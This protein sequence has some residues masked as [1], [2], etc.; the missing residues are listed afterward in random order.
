MTDMTAAGEPFRIG[1]CLS[2]SLSAFFSNFV[3]LNILGVIILIPGAV[4]VYLL[5]GGILT[6]LTSWVETNT[7]L[8]SDMVAP[9]I[10]T[11]L[12]IL[13]IMIVWQYLVTGAV[14]FS[15]V[16]NLSGS[17]PSPFA[18]LAQMLRRLV[19]V[20]L[21]AII[22]TI[23]VWLGL[24]LFIVPGI[25]VALML[26]V[27]IPVVMAEGTGIRASLSRSRVLTKGSRWKLLGLFLV[28]AIGVTIVSELISF[29][30]ELAV[31]L[32]ETGAIIQIVVGIA[33]QVITTVFMAVVLAVTYHDLRVSKEGASTTQI[34]SV[35]D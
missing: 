34:A 32:S 28:A 29:I 7:D 18:S 31:P 25:I 21:V 11:V 23:L 8:P 4:L 26:C 27:A 16:Q 15:V 3:S 6:S 9:I 20:V 35:F 24:L 12:G 5:F 33:L 13:F 2:K 17:K 10:F 19:P 30:V 1:G 14:V 22:S